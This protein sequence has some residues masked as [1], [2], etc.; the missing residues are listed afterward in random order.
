MKIS[1]LKPGQILFDVH[2][3]RMGN[4]TMR[5]LGVWRVLVK[6]VDPE[7]RSFKASWNGN[8]AETKYRIPPNW[9]KTEPFLITSANGYGKRRP[10]KEELAA[11]KAELKSKAKDKNS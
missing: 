8:P 3:H 6:E 9:K 4:T 10:T 2:S 7:G 5:T 1:D 11:H